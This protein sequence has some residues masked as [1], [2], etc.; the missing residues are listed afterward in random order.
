LAAAIPKI[1]EASQ[2]LRIDCQQS[3]Q[4]LPV[5]FGKRGVRVEES[6]HEILQIVQYLAQRGKIHHIHMRNIRGSLNTF[7]EVF[8]DGEVDFSKIVRI[9]RDTQSS[10]AICPDPMPGHHE[11]LPGWNYT[12]KPQL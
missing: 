9:L 5:G 3:I 8:P 1:F 4:Q 7:C 10:G 12:I 11:T 6:G 2:A